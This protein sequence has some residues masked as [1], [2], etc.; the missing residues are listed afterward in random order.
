[1][2]FVNR[3]DELSVLEDWWTSPSERV[4][5]VWGRRRVGKTALLQR[6]AQDRRV[7]FHTAGGRAVPAELQALSRA[8]A[9]ALNG[10]GRDVASRPFRDWDDALETLF[11]EAA[12]DPLLLVFDEFPEL[13]RVS[14]EVPSVLRALLDRTPPGRLKLLLCGS[15]VRTMEAIQEERA[16]LYGRIDR[17]VLLHPFAPHECAALLGSLKPADLALVWGLVGGVPLYLQWWDQDETVRANLQRLVCRPDGRLLTEGQLVLAT[18]GETGEL[19]RLVLQAIASGRTRHHEIADAVRADPT[20]T[21]ERLLR[22]RLVDRVVPVT[23][24]PRRT[25]RRIYRVA[26]NFL[27][28]WLGVVDRYRGEIERGLGPTILPVLMGHLDEHMGPRWEEAYRV[29]LRRMAAGGRLGDGVVAVGPFWREGSE[30]GEIDAVVLAGRRREAVLVG[31]AKWARSL[32]A[33]RILRRLQADLALLPDVS[34]DPR[35][36]VCARERVTSAGDDVL[37]VTAAD[38]FG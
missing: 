36:S 24:D 20:R 7:V 15:A 29:H 5:L 8:A 3:E 30:A 12:R 9:A 17:S 16:P 2:R 18:E 27:A 22:L 23:E 26:D 37:V 10:S 25:R 14:P 28:F 6:F 35:L 13:V 4:A 34:D 21:L 31:E 33:R 32:D 19:A 1:V 38:V 11:A